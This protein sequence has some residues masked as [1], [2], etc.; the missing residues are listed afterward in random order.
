MEGHTISALFVHLWYM[1]AHYNFIHNYVQQFVR[2]S[3]WA[4]TTP[5][6]HRMIST[7][8]WTDCRKLDT[9]QTRYYLMFHIFLYQML[10]W[11]DTLMGLWCLW[12]KAKHKPH[13]RAER[14]KWSYAFGCEYLATGMMASYIL[15]TVVWPAKCI[16]DDS[17]TL[18][19]NMLKHHHYSR[20][21]WNLQTYLPYYQCTQR[22]PTQL[23]SSQ[24]IPHAH[25]L[26]WY[27]QSI[28]LA[29]PLRYLL[30]HVT[31]TP[32]WCWS[33]PVVNLYR[34][35]TVTTSCTQHAL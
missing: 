10:L 3:A 19:I 20:T 31:H 12:R 33:V 21:I 17:C 32:L 11:R 16:Q 5:I 22:V 27:T 4:S 18:L 13:V 6:I 26:V 9:G 25:L 24:H 8:R 35:L 23:V 34:Q 30:M 28:L 1:F 14:A 15:F 2:H 29:P 7:G